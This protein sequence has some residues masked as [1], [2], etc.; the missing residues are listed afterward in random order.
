MPETTGWVSLLPPALAIILAIRT[1]QVILSLFF[2]IWLGWTVLAGWNPLKGFI[3]A[4]E[5][6]VLV[7]TNPGNTKVILFSALMG[8]LLTFTQ[9]SGGMQGFVDKMTRNK[10]ISNHRRAG[11]LTW[12]VGMVIFVESNISVLISGTIARPIFDNLK[13]SREKLAYIC[14]STSAPKCILIPLNAWGAFVIG[15]LTEQGVEQPVMAM[16]SSMPYN[17]YAILAILFVLVV[18]FFRFDIGPMRKAEKRIREEGKVLND[19]AKPVIESDILQINAKAD[20]PK[21][22]FNMV[23]PVLVMVITMP[24]ALW[25]TGGGNIMQGSGSTAVLWSVVAALV[26]GAV[27][28]RIQGIF[29]LDET[30]DQFM[31]GVSGMIPLAALMI[32]AFAIGNV[33][34]ALGTGIYVAGITEAALSPEPV[35]VLL[36][37]VSCVIAFATGTSWGTFAIMIPIGVPMISMMGLNEGLVIAAILGGGVFGDHCSPIS[38]TT[39]I[40]SMASATDHI[41]HIRTQLPYALTAAGI[42]VIAYIILGW[43]F[44]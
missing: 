6:C 44:V 15:L 36:F 42:T 16:V 18:I 1:K 26:A 25:F 19:G 37:L 31:S 21:R 20:V 9:Y 7:F 8:A 2:G 10:L 40:S 30:M 13:I 28:Y 41:D 4:L 29:T 27:S 3:D 33:C 34:K 23:F 24:V 35:P 39:I 12:L 38:D 11:F 22:A 43:F 14:D 17:L 32:F 5:G